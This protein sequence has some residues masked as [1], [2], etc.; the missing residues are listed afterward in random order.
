MADTTANQP[1]LRCIDDDQRHRHSAR[2]QRPFRH[3]TRAPRRCSGVPR[4]GQL[5]FLWSG[6]SYLLDGDRGAL[7]AL[8]GTAA[9]APTWSA[10]GR[11]LAYLASNGGTSGS[12]L[13]VVRKDGGN[14]HTI[15]GLPAA[16]HSYAWSSRGH[17]LDVTLDKRT[18]A[19]LWFADPTGQAGPHPVASRVGL[20]SPDGAT[21]AF[22]AWLSYKDP[23]QRSEVLYT[24]P[25]SGGRP[26][27]RL[28]ARYSGIILLGWW[29]D[30]KG[31]LYRLD[32]QFSASM[33][34]DGL[35]LYTLRLGAA[36]R[37]LPVTLGYPE[38]MAPSPSGRRVLL[39]AGGDRENWNNKSLRICD[40][41]TAAC[42]ALPKPPGTVA[43]DA[44]WAPRGDRIVY[45][46]A[47][48][49]GL[50]YGFNSQAALL[51]W[52]KSRALWVVNT[53]G[54]GA[55]QITAAGTGVYQPRWA[56]D[57]RHVLFVRDDALWLIDTRSGLPARVLGPFPGT[58]DYL[59]FYGHVSWPVQWAWNR[60]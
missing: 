20:L 25:V 33:A 38:Y 32:P 46:Q 15:A 48:D 49:R 21:L 40:I 26:V 36:P 12:A 3:I 52:V 44:D 4:K 58:P 8:P 9:T 22:T 29:P 60:H 14:A 34:A 18:A 42:H 59:G 43:L 27:R 31:L 50:N 23:T 54:T 51:A 56:G 13:W 17:T 10:D 47:R 24:V 2:T 5:A 19:N 1:A 7:H 11:W 28:F 6:R 16:A 55:R 57:G 39:V 45:V 30:G 41:E 35:P 37:A 53:N